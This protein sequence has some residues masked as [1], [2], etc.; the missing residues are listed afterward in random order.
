MFAFQA[1]SDGTLIE[2]LRET[3]QTVGAA[4]PGISPSASG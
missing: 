2:A 3:E 1:D 4:R